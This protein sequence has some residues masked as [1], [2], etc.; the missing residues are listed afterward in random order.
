[1]KKRYSVWE[2]IKRSVRMKLIVP[3]LRSPH[4]PEYKA[5]GV[6]VGLAWAMTPLVGIQ[7]WLVF[8]TW[9]FF[10]KVLKKSFSLPLGI[11]WTWVTNVVTMIPCY[12]IFYVTGQ[13]LRWNVDN[14]TGY[15]ALSGILHDT[16]MG[17]LGF[18]EQWVL[19]FKLL[20]KDW[21]VSMAIGCL[22][23]VVLGSYFGYK[24]TMR[25]ELARIARKKRKEL[26]NKNGGD[27]E[28]NK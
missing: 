11:A 17:D 15:Q 23:F 19:F 28:T 14:I 12:Y 24:I 2:A 18:W 8:M 27:Y 26:L 16:F 21:G 25:F 6:A 22:P 9:L 7:M 13:I 20:L 3:L 10:K 4:P 5:R 1:M